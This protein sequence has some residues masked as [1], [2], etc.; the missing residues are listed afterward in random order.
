MRHSTNSKYLKIS[1]GTVFILVTC[2]NF[3]IANSTKY[4]ADGDAASFISLG[5]SLAK[6]GKYGHLMAE[7]G[8]I[9]A[10]QENRVSEEE[11]P[12]TGHSTWR[13]PVWPL[14][15]AGVFLIFGYNLTYILIFK[16]LLHLL[17]IFIFYKC[18]KLL[19]MK[20][21]LVVV[22]T[23][24][25]GVS[26]AWQ[27]YSRV[28]LSEPITMFFISLWLYFLIRFVQKKSGFLPQAILGGVFVL[29]HPYYI[30]MPFSTWLVLFLKKQIK[31]RALTLSSLL[32]V[33]VI[34]VWII[35]NSVVLEQNS[36][37]LTTSS[38]AVMAK[39]WN[40]N[41]I[42]EHTNTKGDLANEGLVLQNFEAIEEYGH[43]EVERMLLFKDASI[44][45]IKENPD[46]IL[47]IVGRKLL[48]AFNPFPE[49][50]KPGILETG[51][52][53]F[54]LLALLALIYI[55]IFSQNKLAQSLAIGLILATVTMTILT[56]SG[57]RFRMPQA[58]L[59]LLLIIFAA[60]DVLQRRGRNWI[61]S[62]AHHMLQ[63]CRE[64]K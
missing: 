43:H 57:F 34:S 23:F 39:G 33:A 60:S 24:L 35:R 14:L 48:S 18:L 42:E 52:Y 7:R 51:R 58:S 4:E 32:A 3:Y 15:I 13:P 19:E 12:F 61:N 37:V 36:I 49:T 1:L 46:L 55:L 59:E 27:I 6:H 26:P 45:F 54:H 38:G 11:L 50:Q 56:Y 22:G 9:K 30:F 8:I 5:I 40:K 64:L 10:F 31:F 21:V 44:H 16:F 62:A 47:P 20:E 41:V 29:S 63:S 53:V 2:Y 28:F 25:Y 17:G